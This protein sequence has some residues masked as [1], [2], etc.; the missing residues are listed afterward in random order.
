MGANLMFY[1]IQGD[2]QKLQVMANSK[3]HKD[4]KYSFD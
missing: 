3:F 2:G 1:D 4:D